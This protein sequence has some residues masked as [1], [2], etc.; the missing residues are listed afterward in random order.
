MRQILFLFFMLAMSC[1]RGRN[2]VDI[3]NDTDSEIEVTVYGKPKREFNNGNYKSGD[4]EN[5]SGYIKL[6]PRCKVHVSSVG[7]SEISIKDLGFE[8]LRIICDSDTLNKRDKELLKLFTK[9]SE[10]G[11]AKWEFHYKKPANSIRP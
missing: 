5:Y 2:S 4:W 3:Y 11:F 9:T 1:S 7:N 8:S 10:Y 6:K